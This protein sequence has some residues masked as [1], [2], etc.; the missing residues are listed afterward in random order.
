MFT[1][2]LYNLSH[3]MDTL[4]YRKYM[5]NGKLLYHGVQKGRQPSAG[6]RSSKLLLALPRAVYLSVHRDKAVFLL[7]GTIVWTKGTSRDNIQNDTI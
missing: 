7:H 2:K 5:I 3:E 4:Y 6:P 1:D